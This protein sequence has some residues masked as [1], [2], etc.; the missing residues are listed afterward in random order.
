MNDLSDSDKDKLE[1]IRNFY[2]S[3]YHR[4][5]KSKLPNRHDFSLAKKIGIKQD[6]KVLDIACGTGEWLQACKIFGAIP[7]GID[8]SIRAIEVCNL[9]MPEGEFH[10]QQAED[11]PFQDNS[12]DVVTCLGSLEHFVDPVNALKEMVRVAKDNAIFIILVPNSG[13]LTRRLGLFSGTYQVD[14]LEK[15]RSLEEWNNL[16]TSAG[17]IIRDRWKD[18]HILSWSWIN[19]GKWH[20]IPLRLS[21]ALVMPLWPLGWQYQVYHRCVLNKEY[22]PDNA[23]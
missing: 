2:D 20:Q 9:A 16:F 23:E 5:S 10:A 21:Q 4:N 3:I 1:D 22:K 14:A 19:K 7:H 15:V 17:L 13:F 8:L 11:L 6:Q 18:L 12:F